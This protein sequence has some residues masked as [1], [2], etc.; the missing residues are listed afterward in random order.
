MIICHEGSV[1]SF[2][3][4]EQSVFFNDLKNSEW[5]SINVERILNVR[6]GLVSLVKCINSYW[7]AS[8]YS[9]YKV[10]DIHYSQRN[11]WEHESYHDTCRRNKI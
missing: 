8:L 5:R 10:K 7:K 9:C 4:H 1:G 3:G 2:S 6:K 11:H